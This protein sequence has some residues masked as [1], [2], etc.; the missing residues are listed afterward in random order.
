MRAVITGSAGHLGEG[1]A[2]AL[3]GRGWDVCGVDV[4]SSAYTTHVG[5]ILN[6]TLLSSCMEGADVVFHTS[7]L[8]KRHLMQK[9]VADFIQVNVQGTATVLE[10]ALAK[11]VP[12]VIYSS[13]T[14]VYGAAFKPSADQPAILVDEELPCIPKDIYGVTKRA[15]EDICEL[16]ARTRGMKCRVLRVGRFYPESDVAASDGAKPF[17]DLNEKINDLL[18]RR[19]DLLDVVEAH[20]AV[21]G[22]SPVSFR[23]YVVSAPS[24]FGS[25]HLERLRTGLPALL[26]ELEPEWAAVYASLGWK[27]PLDIGRVYSAALIQLET[28]WV[29]KHTFR[30]ALAQLKAGKQ[31]FSDL[32]LVVGCKGYSL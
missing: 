30:S 12:Q 16:Y 17:D 28:G 7:S 25:G 22:K 29:P 9:T 8:H 5:T 20:L 2:R 6:D 24:P 31:P 27:L 4:R 13:T 26:T 15:A 3:V 14:S 11:R 23:R 1:I 21:L 32:A 18:Y 19:I 10:C